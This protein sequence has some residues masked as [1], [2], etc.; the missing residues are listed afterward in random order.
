MNLKIPI[1]V[2]GQTISLQKRIEGFKIRA[3]YLLLYVP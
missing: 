2:Q 1:K 3:T